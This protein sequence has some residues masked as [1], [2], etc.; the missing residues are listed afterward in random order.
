MSSGLA[1]FHS[2]PDREAA[3]QLAAR[4]AEGGLHAT[5]VENSPVFDVTF[6]AGLERDFHVMLPREEFDRAGRL[7]EQDAER[8]AWTLPADHYLHGFSNEELLEVLQKPDEWAPPDRVMAHRLLR[9]RGMDLEQRD[10][11]RMR[12][13]RLAELARPEKARASLII[14]GMAMVLFGGVVGMAIGYSLANAS[15]T[16]PDG[17]RV[18]RYTAE[19]RRV[20]RY[21]MVAGALFTLA[22]L[23]IMFT[24]WPLW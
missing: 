19:D 5:V 17:R 11:E 12:L 6:T 3:E 22:T 21:I 23:A 1:S 13:E 2:T 15:K 4:L 14:A 16:L 7:L 8:D 20:G 18:T 9:Q 24:G 10:L